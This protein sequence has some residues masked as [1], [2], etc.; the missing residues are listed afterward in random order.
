MQELSN[1]PDPNVPDADLKRLLSRMEDDIR[2]LRT[3]V[4]NKVDSTKD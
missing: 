1:L 4:E 3:V 2:T